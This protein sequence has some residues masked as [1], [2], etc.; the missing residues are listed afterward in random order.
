VKRERPAVLVVTER[1]VGLA[2]TVAKAR[3][4]PDLPMVVLP[5]GMEQMTRAELEEVA[6][7]TLDEAGKVFTRPP[8]PSGS[9]RTS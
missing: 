5:A 7:K 2:K 4:L 9:A 1:F 3:G 8:S 6:R